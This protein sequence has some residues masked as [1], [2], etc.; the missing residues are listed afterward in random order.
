MNDNVSSGSS[1][2]TRTSE[3]FPDM[4][5][6]QLSL[7]LPIDL[8]WDDAVASPTAFDTSTT[9]KDLDVLIS[10]RNLFAFLIGQSLV[11]TQK[12]PTVFDIFLQIA[13]SL[14]SYD[15]TNFDASSFGEVAS[16]S[17][18]EYVEELGLGDVRSSCEKTIEAVVLGERMK[19]VLLYDE[20]FIHAAG[21]Y[22][23]IQHL[24][25]KQGAAWKF[26]AISAVTR[27][28]LERA[29]IDL[30]HREKSIN[31]RLLDFE[32]PSIFAGIINSRSVDE[33]KVLQ[34]GAWKDAFLATRK[35]VLAYYRHTYGA[36]PPKANGKKNDLETSGLNRSVIQAV[37][38]DF[39]DLYDLWV[40]RTSLT[41]RS[42]ERSETEAEEPDPEE[43]IARILRRV[44]DEYDRSSPPVQ[45]AVPYDI[46]L[47]PS[48]ALGNRYT[49]KSRTKKL[50]DDEIAPLLDASTNADTLPK[51]S[52]STF[53]A[54]IRHF[55]RRA[56]RRG[57]ATPAHLVNLRV[58]AWIFCY[59][60][61]QALPMLAVD[62][63]GVRHT[64]RVEYFLCEPPRSG[65]PWL[66]VGAGAGGARG[67]QSWYGIAGGAGGVVSLPSDLVEHGVEGV[68]RRSH[69]WVQAARWSDTLPDRA[70]HAAAIA[71]ATDRAPPPQPPP[72]PLGARSGGGRGVRPAPGARDDLDALPAHVFTGDPLQ[73]SPTTRSVARESVLSLGLEALPL[74]SGMVMSAVGGGGGGGGGGGTGSRA[75]SRPGTGSRAASVRAE[76]TARNTGRTFDDI[77]SE[78]G[79]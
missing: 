60:V 77:F 57:C 46:P 38:R 26:E 70:A 20:A 7:Y 71:A 5:N 43:P 74:P 58:G 22:S 37:Y 27:S 55:E 36:W 56:V 2:G 13:E 64:S 32:F 14:R 61:L 63:P 73:S 17:F 15:F 59:A 52:T 49:A 54:S 40:D 48:P 45:P 21:K 72:P 62:A 69:C 33:R 6:R 41:T 24:G 30:Y 3:D 23:D 31:T 1:R 34:F 75:S 19:S 66:S 44:F 67:R 47:L 65:A 28:R 79:R 12:C 51:T 18:D 50:R 76:E 16:T 42:S 35:H 10:A 78:M 8:S 25:R 11:S 68:Y 9:E 53:L 4:P 29:S 39:A